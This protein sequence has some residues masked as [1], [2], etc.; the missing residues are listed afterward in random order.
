MHIRNWQWQTGAA[1]L[2]ALGLTLLIL[3]LATA[4]H[5]LQAAPRAQDISCEDLLG[6]QDSQERELGV[7]RREQD[8]F[9][10][11]ITGIAHFY[12]FT[13]KEYTLNIADRWQS[14][15]AGSRFNPYEI[16]IELPP[17]EYEYHAY[18]AG[19][20]VGGS[21]YVFETLT[22]PAAIGQPYQKPAPPAAVGPYMPPNERLSTL[23]FWNSSTFEVTV[24]VY[25]ESHLRE[26]NATYALTPQSINQSYSSHARVLDQPSELILFVP[27]GN[28]DYSLRFEL[29]VTRQQAD[30]KGCGE[31]Y[32]QAEQLGL[33]QT[34]VVRRGQVALVEFP[35]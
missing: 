3:L 20:V 4:P 11:R 14:L 30:S 9:P 24:T 33:L 12:N 26:P 10:T 22:W 8:V 23:V 21:T 5:G 16:W 13:A 31:Q 2:R 28:I 7:Q 19:G 27:P 15:H 17:G 6:L 32:D 34:K 25:G 35:R 18:H 1:M 29:P